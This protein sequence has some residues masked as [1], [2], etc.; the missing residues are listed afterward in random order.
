MSEMVLCTTCNS[1][2]ED[3]LINGMCVDCFDLYLDI[4]KDVENS[5]K[6]KSLEKRRSENGY[7]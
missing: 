7:Y 4:G 2:D 6:K 1:H 5:D 3:G